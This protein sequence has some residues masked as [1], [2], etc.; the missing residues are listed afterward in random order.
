VSW[1]DRFIA[2]IAT[3]KA[4]ASAHHVKYTNAEALAAA[5]ANIDE[6]NLT[7]LL[8]NGSF[9]AGDPPAGWTLGGAGA[10]LSRSAAQVK[11]GGYSALLTRVGA[12]CY[13]AQDPLDYA[14]YKGK[15]LTFG[16]WVYATVASRARIRITD[17]AGAS[18]SDYHSGAA[19]WE[20]L[21]VTRE[22]DAA[23]ATI[24][25]GGYILT[26]N[27]SAYFDGAILVEGDSCPSF[28]PMPD[29]ALICHHTA[30]YTISPYEIGHVVH[31]NLGAG[32]VV[33]LT[34]PQTV[35]AGFVVHF[36]V[37]EAQELRI[38]PGAAGAIY[39]NGAKQTDNKYIWADDEGESITLVADGNGD[40]ASLYG[41][42]T[43]GVEL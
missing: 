23:A 40:W 39:V 31:T 20:W 35:R 32:G 12:N 15:N 16:C 3:H 1:I 13:I 8:Q 6:K 30:A 29:Q 4:D 5:W 9:E 25:A 42:G 38:T 41:V 2:A 11:I 28:L 43:W 17:S 27:T 26:G 18:S 37:M 36:T 7:N 14:R 24:T 34:L 33:T 21:T 22:I 10:T 19:G